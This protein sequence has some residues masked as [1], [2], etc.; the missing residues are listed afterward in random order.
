MN[1]AIHSI[2]CAT[3]YA[4]RHEMPRDLKARLVREFAPEVNRL[5]ELIDRDLSHW[6]R[7]PAA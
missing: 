7:V 3:G 2:V 6:N 1:D 5:A 4:R